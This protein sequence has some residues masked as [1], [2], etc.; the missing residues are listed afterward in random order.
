MYETRNSGIIAHLPKYRRFDKTRIAEMQI[1]L[2]GSYN[3]Y[4]KEA[5]SQ[6]RDY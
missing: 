6:I 5:Y 4:K 1:L 3:D 2:G